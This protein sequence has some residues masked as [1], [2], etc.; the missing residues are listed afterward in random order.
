M[1]T[2]TPT[3]TNKQPLVMKRGEGETIKALGSEITFLCRE[4]G[5]WSL[6]RVSVPRDVGA[7]PHD[8]DFD[9]SYYVLSGSLQLTVAG[10]QVELDAGEFVLIPGKTVHA[11]KGTSDVPTHFLIHQSPGDAEEFF[12]ACAREIKKIPEDLARM[13]EIGA[14]YG[15]RMAPLSRNAPPR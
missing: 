9:E 13:P 7:A 11:F 15:I 8:H 10:K 5:A 6:M 12:R 2:S 4:P 14:R 1:N 3:E